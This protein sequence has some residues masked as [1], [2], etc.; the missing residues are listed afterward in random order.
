LQGF[1]FNPKF[2]LFKMNLNNAMR[3]WIGKATLLASLF[4]VFGCTNTATHSESKTKIIALGGS[5]TE[6]L[7]ALGVDSQLVGVDVTS[8]Y[9][10]SLSE[11]PRV[12]HVRSLSAE[13]MLALQPDLILDGAGMELSLLNQLKESGAEVISLPLANNADSALAQ[14]LR[15]GKAVKKEKESEDLVNRCRETLSSLAQLQN[16]ESPKPKVIFIYSRGQGNLTVA[17]GNTQAG[18]MLQLAGAENPYETEFEG[19]RP[20]T[21]EGLLL[22]APDVLFLFTDAFEALGGA[23]GLLSIPGVAETPAGKNLR[24]VHLDGHYSTGFGPRFAE[25]ATELYHLFKSRPSP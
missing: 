6:T 19:F 23:E 14:F 12:G 25:A 17:G 9:P 21:A 22:A 13:K 7:H 2:A 11:L 16:R 24:F 10:S 20:L 3:N 18:A 4:S 8:T 15:V 1:C 5:V